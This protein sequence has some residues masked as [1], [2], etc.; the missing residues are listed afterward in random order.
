MRLSRAQL[1]APCKNF[2]QIECQ[3]QQITA[4]GG[5]ELIRRYFHVIGLR[6]RI[7]RVFQGHQCGDRSAYGRCLFQQRTG[8][9]ARDEKG[10]VYHQ[11]LNFM[12]GLPG[13]LHAMPIHSFS[14]P[15]G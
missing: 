14:A 12:S 1:K 8:D 15:A 11:R 2:F 10:R 13:V 4:Y 6:R 5:L 9:P 7:Q 3:P